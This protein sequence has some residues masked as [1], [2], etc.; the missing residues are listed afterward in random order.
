MAYAPG[1]RNQNPLPAFENRIEKLNNL[2]LTQKRTEVDIAVDGGVSED[3]MADYKKCGANFFILG[4]SGLFVP[5]TDLKTQI[6]KIRN[7]LQI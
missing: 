2:L 1:I 6:S 3:K 7:I 5:H 4:S